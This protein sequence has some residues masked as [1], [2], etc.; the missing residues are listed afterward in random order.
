MSAAERS[1][2]GAGPDGRRTRPRDASE[3]QARRRQVRRHRHL[4]R[5]DVG[6]GL[7]AALVLII[8]TP[9]LAISGLLALVVLGACLFS[10]RRE[11]RGHRGRG[12]RAR[13]A[14]RGRSGRG[15][16]AAVGAGEAVARPRRSSRW[17]S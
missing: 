4:A 8:A 3:L 17:P 6:L 1:S 15:D 7:L 11:R 5:V 13:R 2:D 9:G 12:R 16:R 10:L 14:A